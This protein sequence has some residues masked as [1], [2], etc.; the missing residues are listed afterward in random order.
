[1]RISEAATD[2][3]EI[4]SVCVNDLPLEY[5]LETQS[6]PNGLRDYYIKFQWLEERPLSQNLEGMQLVS[7]APSDLSPQVTVTTSSQLIPEIQLPIKSRL[8]STVEIAPNSWAVGLVQPS[9]SIQQQFRISSHAPGE[10][11]V[12]LLHAPEGIQCTLL[13]RTNRGNGV[14][15]QAKGRL[16]RHGILDDHIRVKVECGQVDSHLEIPV[17]GFVSGN[18]DSNKGPKQ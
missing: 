17:V 18:R 3:F 11:S 1:V 16:N 5:S 8:Q 4:E 2:R 12:K 10:L 9:D 7:S 13:P 6:R 15:L 14:M